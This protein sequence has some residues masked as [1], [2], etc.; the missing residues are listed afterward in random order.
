M[1]PGSDRSFGLVMAAAFSVVSL[2]PLRHRLPPRTWALAVAVVFTA[3]A[4]ARPGLLRPLNVAWTKFGL[5][6]NRLTTP[7]LLALVFFLG[8]LPTGALMRAFG[9]D[10]MRRKRNPSAA[11]YWIV[12]P[13]DDGS[14]MTRQF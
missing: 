7:V 2:L 4:L 1:Q 14:T 13:P 3:V 9:R 5:L 12:R 8:V 6:L 11:S 10:P